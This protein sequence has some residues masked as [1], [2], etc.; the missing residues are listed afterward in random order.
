MSVFNEGYNKSNNFFI[1][2]FNNL[3]IDSK[4]NKFVDLTSSGGT[5]LLGHNNTILKRSLKKFVNSG[6]S[7]FALPNEHAKNFTKNIK[8]ILPQFSKIIF[9]NSGA[10]AN[11]K[12]IRIFLREY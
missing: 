5:S 3:I 2:G 4:N 9:C 10:E 8:K 7:N 1:K 6:F 11:L 12:A